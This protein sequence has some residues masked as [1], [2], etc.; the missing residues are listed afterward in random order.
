[1]GGL[2]T[3]EGDGWM[4]RTLL[5]G[6]WRGRVTADNEEGERDETGTQEEKWRKPKGMLAHYCMLYMGNGDLR[7]K[8][9]GKTPTSSGRESD[10]ATAIAILYVD[11]CE[12]IQWQHGPVHILPNRHL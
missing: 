4:E 10:H 5:D 12:S 6:G 3:K 7:K 11:E 2:G 9:N 1:M 8:V